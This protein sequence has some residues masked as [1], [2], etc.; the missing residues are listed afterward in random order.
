MPLPPLLEIIPPD[1]PVQAAITVPG[2]KSITNR[3]LVL[4]A[5]APNEATV[6]G[7]LWSDDTQVM[8]QALERLGFSLNVAPDPVE[9][10]NRTI[11][12][13]GL[14]GKIPQAG[15]VEKPLELFVGNAGT[16]ARF[17]TAMVCLGHGLYRLDGVP[18]MRERP[19]QPLFGALRELGYCLD[20]VNNKLPVVVHATGPRPGT[21]CV[22]LAGSS[23]FAS[24]LR[25]CAA[26]GGWRVSVV[27]ENAEESPYLAMTEKLLRQFPPGGGE[28]AVEP[29]ASSGSYFWAADAL[30]RLRFGGAGRIEVLGWPQTDWQI[31]AQFPRYLPLPERIS[32][33]DQLG[34]SILTAMVLAPFASHPVAFTHLHPL[35]VQECERVLAMR[36]ELSRCGVRVQEEGDTLTVFPSP[37]HGAEIETYQDHRIAMGFAILGL[38]VPGI[39]IK[40]S[41][42]VEKTFPDF[43][44]RLAAAPPR[45]L[46]VTLRDPA[47]GRVLSEADRSAY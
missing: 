36:T 5:L 7:A 43:F 24:A 4:A 33:R 40:N 45:G 10:G 37:V 20:S 28:F 16:A 46:G 9:H 38:K 44:Q 47:T 18:R 23:Q 39:K 42:C 41:A 21:C 30:Q 32:R 19:Q 3:A 22:S 26:A 2:S 12:V 35:R 17:L 29:D 14:G 25:L 31:D 8:V 34:D 13:R 15:T 27:G 11:T 6:R 1:E